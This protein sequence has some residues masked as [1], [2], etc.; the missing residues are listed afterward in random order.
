MAAEATLTEEIMLGNNQFNIDDILPFLEQMVKSLKEREFNTGMVEGRLPMEQR[1]AP[2]T[3]ELSSGIPQRQ[4]TAQRPD[5]LLRTV[6]GPSAPLANISNTLPQ[7]KQEFDAA[8]VI[9]NLITRPQKPTSG[10]FPAFW[11]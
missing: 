11:F 7:A 8:Q 5:M 2:P 3:R 4:T 9:S 6:Y 10:L 1:S